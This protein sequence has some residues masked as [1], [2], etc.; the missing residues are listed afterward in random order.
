MPYYDYECTA[1]GTEFELFTRSMV[2][3]SEETPP[4]C[5]HCASAQT[6]RRV[7]RVAVLRNASPGFGQSAYPTSW[8]AVNHGDKDTIDY[9]RRR[10]EKEKS[11]EARDS[12]LR[13]ERLISAERRYDEVVAHTTPVPPVTPETPAATEDVAT[14]DETGVTA[15]ATGG[16][17]HGAGGHTHG[18]GGHSH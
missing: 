13:H 10:V 3:S 16:R 6:E 15:T 8:S 1:C 7:S 9:W 14:D 17:E 2:S 11:E 5:P 18:P 12:G 4:S